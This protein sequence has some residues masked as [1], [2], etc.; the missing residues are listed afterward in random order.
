MSVTADVGIERVAEPELMEDAEQVAA[1]AQA[2]LE[3]LHA[4]LVPGYRERLGEARGRGVD[5][6]CGPGAVGRRFLAAF[7]KLELVGVDGSE[8][9]VRAAESAAARAGLAGRWRSQHLRL[10]AAA[11]PAQ[12]FDLVLSNFL[13]HHLDHAGVLWET[14]KQCA[15]AGAAVYVAD[16]AR[17]ASTAAMEE[18][19]Q[20]HAGDAHPRL[21]ED[22]FASLRAAYTPA[23]VEAQLEQYGVGGLR[24]ERM[25][26][27][28]LLAWGRMSA[29]R[30]TSRA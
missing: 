24:V 16:L 4:P 26:T 6:G 22:F 18:L 28:Q 2:D 3:E 5:L 9:M 17:P 25:G 23:E 8:L 11:L 15:R 13:L 20:Q 29:I 10:P 7:P 21:Q 30:R 1:Y 27:F 14:V 12:E 19:V